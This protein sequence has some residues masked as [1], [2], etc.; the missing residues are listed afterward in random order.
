VARTLA[1]PTA[2]EGVG[3]LPVQ[4][5]VIRRG[6]VPSGVGEFGLDDIESFDSPAVLDFPSHFLGELVLTLPDVTFAARDVI[7]G[8]SDVAFEPV[9]P[10]EQRGFVVAAP[11][12]KLGEATEFGQLPPGVLEPPDRF[13]PVLEGVGEVPLGVAKVSETLGRAGGQDL[14]MFGPFGEELGEPA[15]RVVDGEAGVRDA[16]QGVEHF[17]VGGA[18]VGE[19]AAVV[20][21][22]EAGDV[23][24]VGGVA[25]AALARVAG[26]AFE[27]GGAEEVDLGPG[28]ALDAV[29][30]QRNAKLVL[31]VVLGGDGSG[32]DLYRRRAPGERGC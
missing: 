17:L 4:E 26:E 13:L 24:G 10:V 18:L 25:G 7:F 31:S 30:D 19:D 32:Y 27:G 1:A 3:T 6:V 22:G 12:A 15:G 14:L 23:P 20:D 16:S 5:R 8:A 28:A 9:D 29:D 21:V 2:E 11:A